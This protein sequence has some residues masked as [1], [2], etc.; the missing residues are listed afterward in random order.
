MGQNL[1]IFGAT[2]KTRPDWNQPQPEFSTP[3]AASAWLN[4][5]AAKEPY[6]GTLKA[7]CV[8]ALSEDEGVFNFKLHKSTGENCVL[9]FIGKL[10]EGATQPFEMFGFDIRAIMKIIAFEAAEKGSSLPRAMW[11]G[12]EPKY[13]DTENVVTPEKNNTFAQATARLLPAGFTQREDTAKHRVVMTAM[14]LRRL[15]LYPALNDQLDKLVEKL[16]ADKVEA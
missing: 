7:L 3:K 6:S 10:G 5:S 15:G 13:F 1:L 11:Y 8:A 14:F 4:E 16:T 12:S 9:G 2:F